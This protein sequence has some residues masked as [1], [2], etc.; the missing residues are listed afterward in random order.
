MASDTKYLRQR[1][2]EWWLHYRIPT[3]FKLLPECIKFNGIAT[4]SLKTDSL[5]EARRKRDGFIH[6]LEMQVD[7]HDQ[8]WL[9]ERG[10]IS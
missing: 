9:P 7:N 8:A 10:Y 5:R 2:G 6:V 3:Q 4:F 1:G